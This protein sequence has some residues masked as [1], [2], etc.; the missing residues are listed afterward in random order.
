LARIDYHGVSRLVEPYSLRMPKTGNLLL[1]VHEVERGGAEGE[2]I[3][4]FSV[5]ELGEVAIT[6]QPFHPRWAIEL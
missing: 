3:K 4:S 1:Y 5:E 2:G 6:E